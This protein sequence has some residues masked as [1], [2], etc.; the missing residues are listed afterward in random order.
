MLSQDE[1]ASENLVRLESYL[2]VISGISESG[3]LIDTIKKIMKKEWF[4]INQSSHQRALLVGFVGNRK[5]SFETEEG[6]DF[7]QDVIVKLAKVNEYSAFRVLGT[8]G[9]VNGMRESIQKDM[10]DVL[11]E[12]LVRL[13][14]VECDGVKN[15][16]KNILGRLDV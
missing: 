10:K 12:V 7:L 8:I 2:G 15:N 9:Q 4:D 11:D 6:L 1:W 3:L 16:I 14:D 5:V 13:K